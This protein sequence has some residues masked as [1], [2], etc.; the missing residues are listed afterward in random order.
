MKRTTTLLA[1]CL[2]GWAIGPSH[3]VL[4]ASKGAVRISYDSKQDR[5]L[6]VWTDGRDSL[7]HSIG[8]LPVS[9][10]REPEPGHQPGDRSRHSH[11]Y[12]AGRTALC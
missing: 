12:G 2:L 1:L 8:G 3:A 9:T 6:V 10:I 7:G 11:R 4:A 5:Y